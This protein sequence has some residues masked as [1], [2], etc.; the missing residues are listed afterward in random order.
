M[1]NDE[2]THDEHSVSDLMLAD[3]SAEDDHARF[4]RHTRSFV[5]SSNIL[6]DVEY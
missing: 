3:T 4:F 6:Y 1:Q 2:V 5:E